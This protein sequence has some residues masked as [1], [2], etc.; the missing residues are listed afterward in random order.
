MEPQRLV[1][2]PVELGDMYERAWKEWAESGE[3]ELW[4]N[5]PWEAWGDDCNDDEVIES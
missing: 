1:I 3:A 2:D 4:E 5:L